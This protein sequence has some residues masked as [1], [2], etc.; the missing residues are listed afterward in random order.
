MVWG[1]T[2]R[3]HS[4]TSGF[5]EV[6]RKE[7]FRKLTVCLWCMHARSQ[8]GVLAVLLYHSSC[9][10]EN[11]LFLFYFFNFMCGCFAC[12]SEKKVSPFWL[13]WLLRF[14]GLSL[15]CWSYRHMW[16]YQGF[17]WVLG[18]WTSVLMVAQQLLSTPSHRPCYHKKQWHLP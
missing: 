3:A 12:F 8:R 6:G 7:N 16:P 17:P 11:R 1:A 9:S 10:P 2:S 14:D 4:D 15:Q 18:I 5:W 13:G